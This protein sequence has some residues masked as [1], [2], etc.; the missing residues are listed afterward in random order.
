MFY[1]LFYGKCRETDIMPAIPAISDD[2]EEDDDNVADPDFVT[3][4]KWH[5]PF[6]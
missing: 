5:G 1:Q 6:F 3:L 4:H 2:E